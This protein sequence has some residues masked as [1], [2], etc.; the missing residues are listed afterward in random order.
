V[1]RA[2]HPLPTHP[3][4]VQD[5]TLLYLLLNWRFISSGCFF[6][7]CVGQFVIYTPMHRDHYKLYFGATPRILCG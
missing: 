4:V 5:T 7:R 2:I 6:F 3:D 1:K